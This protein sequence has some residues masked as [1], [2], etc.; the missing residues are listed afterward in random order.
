MVLP[1]KNIEFKIRLPKIPDSLSLFELRS[2][3]IEE[4]QHAISIFTETLKL[5]D[6]T[7]FELKDSLVFASRRG[8]VEYFYASGSLWAR[9]A[10]VGQ[11]A[12]NE[13]RKWDGLEKKGVQGETWYVLDK[14]MTERLSKQA[15]ELLRKAELLRDRA[16]LD[17]VELDQ[18]AQLD[19]KGREI[20]SGVG[21]ATIKF[22]YTVECIPVYGPGA[23]TLIFAEPEDGK[24]RIT[25]AFHAWREI[26]D[27][28]KLKLPDIEES[29]AVGL[30]QD[31]ELLMYHERGHKIQVTRLDFGY[32]A[33]PAFSKQSYLFPAY[34]VE[35]SILNPKDESEFFFGR[36]Y[37]AASPQ[38]Y[39]EA[40]THAHYL[41]GRL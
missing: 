13:E 10:T 28:R 39:K 23:K 34:Q 6:L 14:H 9:D 16:S 4:R 5:G 31:P 20:R 2:P 37:H 40:K 27:S 32:F 24:P 3:L 35:G 17:S 12:E 30:L 41:F 22:L 1:L 36:Y 15:H 19:E 25:G 29:L 8:E 18:F 26:G 38:H 33:L 21:S 7:R 11:K